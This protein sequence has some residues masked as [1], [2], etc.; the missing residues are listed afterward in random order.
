MGTQNNGHEFFANLN[1]LE[2]NRL[3]QQL[4][5]DSNKTL[6]ERKKNGQFST[7]YKLA[8]EIVS[9]GM[10]LCNF[11]NINFLEPCVG[12]GVFFSALLSEV[13]N[14]VLLNSVT[15]IEID[16]SY[17]DCARNIWNSLGFQLINE[18]FS[19]SEPDKLYNLVITN[20][21]YIRHQSI[22]GKHKMYL[23]EKTKFETGITLSGL[24]GIYCYLLILS[25]KWLAPDAIS[26]WLLPSEF[27]DVNYGIA[28]KNYLLNNVRLLRIHRYPPESSRFSE[29]IVS[30]CVV[31]FKNEKISEDYYIEFTLGETHDKPLERKS[32]RKSVLLTEK[33]WT[34]FPEKPIRFI[35]AEKGKTLGDY[36]EVKRGIATGDNSF[37]IMG[38]DKILDLGI[39]MK[40]FKPIL[41][42]PRFLKT[43]FIDTKSDGLP[44]LEQQYFLLDC[45]LSESEVRNESYSLWR[46][47]QSGVE[48]T[49]QKYLC[50]KRKC[51]YWQEQRQPSYFLC[52]YM[53]RSKDGESPVRFILNL[54]QAIVNNSYLILY[55][56]KNLQKFLEKNPDNKFHVWEILKKISENNIHDEGR[57][58]G[59]GLEKIE[60]KELVN[61]S[62]GDL[63]L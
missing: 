30:S 6:S 47:L 32:V 58:Y 3:T 16:S 56:K 33:K 12:T 52:S 7:P 45:R 35:D 59:G 1:F 4:N 5:V 38:Y 14:E 9:Y 18:D 53:G 13:K 15:G 62:C 51:W 50:R 63:I 44:M 61:V 48:K 36:F 8:K 46:Y 57:I 40:F 28:I 2:S 39:D 29:A 10:S 42:S 31:W 21:P 34:R 26:G 37:F 43:N 23:K 11:E 41:P 54:S 17:C 60:P 19:H 24:S 27:M 25:H 55:P 20:P 22:E 49:G